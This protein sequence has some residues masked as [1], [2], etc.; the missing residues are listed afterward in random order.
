MFGPITAS[1][2]TVNFIL[3]VAVLYL[4]V[5][6]RL[7]QEVPVFFTLIVVSVGCTTVLQIL[8][9]LDWRMSYY[10]VSWIGRGIQDMLGIAVVHE[11][12]RR[13]LYPYDGLRN[14]ASTVFWIAIIVLLGAA[15]ASEATMPNNGWYD[16][17]TRSLGGL[18]RALLLLSA[19]LMLVV[20]ALVALCGMPWRR[21]VF[22]IA[23]GLGVYA[24]LKLALTTVY[25][26]LGM[27][28]YAGYTVAVM[29]NGIL[30]A[31]LWLGYVAVPEREP[32]AARV[33]HYGLDR[34]NHALLEVLQR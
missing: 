12:L 33:V 18:H 4:L 9:G 27:D 11:V 5:R 23:F 32:Q 19:G 15:V 17:M 24:S 8:A 1:L 10:Y 25:S 28:W 34:W 3:L 6:R 30:Q 26:Y 22:G 21:L 7:W 29:G 16:T 2:W 31:G 20:F 13:V 14:L